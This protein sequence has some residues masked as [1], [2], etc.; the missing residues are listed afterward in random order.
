M[1]HIRQVLNGRYEIIALLGEGGMGAVYRA[2]D[3]LF[4]RPVALKEFRLGDLPSEADFMEKSDETRLRDSRPQ[5]LTREKALEQFTSEAMLLARLEHP[6]LPKVFDF[7]TLSFE[8]YISMS[9]IEGSSLEDMLKSSG[10]PLPEEQVQGWLLQIMDA[11]AYCHQRGVIHRDLKPA[12]LLLGSN[13]L[14]YLVDFGIAKM[15]VAGQN[16]TSTGARAYSPGYAPPEQ[17]SGRGGT[18]PSSDIYSLGATAYALL[19]GITPT[20]PND[21]ISGEPLPLPRSINPAISERMQG[22]LLACLHL[23]K[24]DRPQDIISARSLL[25]G[26]QPLPEQTVIREPV[27]PPAPDVPTPPS[28]NSRPVT[29]PADLPAI[30]PVVPPIQPGAAAQNSLRAKYEAALPPQP[31]RRKKKFRPWLVAIL[32]IISGCI[33]LIVGINL[34]NDDQLS[35]STATSGGAAAKPTAVRSPLPQTTTV[36]N[37]VTAQPVAGAATSAACANPDAEISRNSHSVVKN[38]LRSFTYK[39]YFSRPGGWED[40]RYS[41]SMQPRSPASSVYCGTGSGRIQ[42]KPLSTNPELLFCQHLISF[43]IDSASRSSTVYCDY[44]IQLYEETC[45]LVYSY[46]Y[47]YEFPVA[48]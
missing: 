13:G 9:L 12:N 21:Q 3:K 14:V 30:Q 39:V 36:K 42:C 20:E 28:S 31:A 43:S 24:A 2:H 29:P 35:E 7:F 48:K 33:L 5:V 38:S 27:L 41:F 47:N 1:L 26:S 16:E 40:G 44:D 25:L 8:G 10:R 18:N 11:L 34:L 19:T 32:V 22:F 23:K 4:D 45:D 15:L 6:N 37:E 46:R 17:Y